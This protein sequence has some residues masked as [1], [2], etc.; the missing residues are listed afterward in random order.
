MSVQRIMLLWIA[1]V[2]VALVSAS[3]A[4]ELSMAQQFSQFQATVRHLH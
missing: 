4:A 1:V 2:G 3:E